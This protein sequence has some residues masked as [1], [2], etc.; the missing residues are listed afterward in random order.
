M[1][2]NF[3][4]MT[5]ILIT[6]FLLFQ[7]LHLRKLKRTLQKKQINRKKESPD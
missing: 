1:N 6:V 2:L 4:V 7:F 5:D 3:M